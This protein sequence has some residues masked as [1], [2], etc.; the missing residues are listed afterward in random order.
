MIEIELPNESVTH[1]T[2]RLPSRFEQQKPESWF[3]ESSFHFP[4][5]D[6]ENRAGTMVDISEEAR[7]HGVKTPLYA[8]WDL[9]ELW[10][11]DGTEETIRRIATL[12]HAF[13]YHVYLDT[14]NSWRLD[15]NVPFFIKRLGLTPVR[16]RATLQTGIKGYIALDVVV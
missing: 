2:T 10:I 6:P 16:V 3:P 15:F 5:I 8:S 13:L 12:C 14:E 7:Q 1:M 11:C 4:E 9:Y